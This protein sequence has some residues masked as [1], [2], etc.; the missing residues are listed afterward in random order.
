MPTCF[1]H[2][3]FKEVFM[4][5]IEDLKAEVESSK[6]YAPERAL[7]LAVIAMAIKDLDSRIACL[8]INAFDY[9][10]SKTF[11]LHCDLLGIPSCRVRRSV[12]EQLD[13]AMVVKAQR[14]ENCRKKCL[15]NEN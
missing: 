11:E 2:L 7:L 14:D 10:F 8:R 5:D 12:Q 4:L 1:K 6:R 9:F 3:F 15:Q 13:A